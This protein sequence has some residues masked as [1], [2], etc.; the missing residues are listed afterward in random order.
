MPTRSLHPEPDHTCNNPACCLSETEATEANGPY[1]SEA[2]PEKPETGNN[3]AKGAFKRWLLWFLAFFGIY[4]SSSICPLC[5][6]P[7]CPV[8]A[9]GAVLVG[10]LFAVLWQY[11]K[12][13]WD[14]FK[15]MVAK[16][17][18]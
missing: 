14:G 2:T 8:G 6:T 7:G 15:R 10:G 12:N 13:F 3:T 1:P 5:G 18:K 16:L 17:E 4:A 11:G 9:G